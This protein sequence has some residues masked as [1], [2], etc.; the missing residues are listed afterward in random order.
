MVG[1]SRDSREVQ[2]GKGTHFTWGDWE[3]GVSELLAESHWEPGVKSRRGGGRGEW[4]WCSEPRKSL[5]RVWVSR[6][7]GV[8]ALRPPEVRGGEGG[9]GTGSQGGSKAQERLWDGRS[10]ALLEQ[11]P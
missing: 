4:A 11:G 1:R 10:K 5:A 3:R 8:A 7:L 6:G 2:R 9:G